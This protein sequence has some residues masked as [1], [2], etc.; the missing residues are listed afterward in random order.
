M[1]MLNKRQQ[2]VLKQVIDS[3]KQINLKKMK[4]ETY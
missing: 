1:I 2:L 4:K 3:L